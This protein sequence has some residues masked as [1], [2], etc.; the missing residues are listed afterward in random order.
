[1][2]LGCVSCSSGGVVAKHKFILED[3]WD[4]GKTLYYVDKGFLQ[5]VK[6]FYQIEATDGLIDECIKAYM[7]SQDLTSGPVEL[8]KES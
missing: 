5:P 8:V 6:G 7:T 2:S 1:M 3:N 4:G